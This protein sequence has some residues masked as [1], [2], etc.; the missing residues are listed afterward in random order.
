MSSNFGILFV[1]GL[2]FAPAATIFGRVI[3]SGHGSIARPCFRTLSEKEKDDR[4]VSFMMK[5][6]TNDI[7]EFA[8]VEL[9]S[10]YLVN[11]I[12]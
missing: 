10:P 8:N 11:Q 3:L 5:F 12:R 6:L 7:R 1:C 9:R 4:R 2:S